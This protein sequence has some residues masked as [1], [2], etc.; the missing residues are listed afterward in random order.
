MNLSVVTPCFSAAATIESIVAPVPDSMNLPKEVI[1]VNAEDR[2]GFGPEI[3]AKIARR[4]CA[5]CCIVE[6]GPLR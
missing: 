6:Y 3:G 2:F 1:V 4:R 5:I